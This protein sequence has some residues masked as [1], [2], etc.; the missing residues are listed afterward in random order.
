MIETII[1]TVFVI[2]GLVLAISLSVFFTAFAI[3]IV[4][5]EFFR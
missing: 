3:M 5:D 2:C 1:V 4:R